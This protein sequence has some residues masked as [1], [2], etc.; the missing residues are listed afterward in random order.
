MQF[1][2]YIEACCISILILFSFFVLQVEKQ[3]NEL[4]RELEDLTE[5]LEEAGGATA[6]QIE[7][8]K[9]REQELLKLRREIEEVTLHSETQISSMKKK[10]QDAQN[11]MSDQIDQ[12]TKSKQK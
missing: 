10:A 9:K 12:L 1:I 7:V 6:A 2:V 11:E 3:R 4:T 8:N 5:R